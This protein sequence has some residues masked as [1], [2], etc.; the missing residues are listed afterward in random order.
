MLNVVR[1]GQVKLFLILL[2]VIGIT[3]CAHGEPERLEHTFSFQ[4]ETDAHSVAVVG[5]FNG[6]DPKHGEMHEVGENCW[7]IRLEMT[8]G[9]HHYKFVV[10]GDQVFEDP[11]ADRKLREGDGF[12]GVNSGIAI[13]K[14]ARKIELT[15]AQR[16][17]M[18]ARVRE[19]QD[20][21]VMQPD[22]KYM[23]RFVYMPSYFVGEDIQSVAVVGSLNGWSKVATP[24]REVGDGAW[25]AEVAL[26]KGVHFYK[27]VINGNRWVNDPMSDREFEL[28]DGFE[29]VNS[30]VIV[31]PDGRKLAAAR[32]NHVNE[33]AIAIE[34]FNVYE[35]GKVL[36]QLRV[37]A[38]DVEGVELNIS[39]I[40]SSDWQACL[41]EMIDRAM[42]FDLFSGV[43]ESDAR[44]VRY[45]FTIRDGNKTVYLADKVMTDDVEEAKR[46]A[47][48]EEMNYDFNVPEWAKH[49][50]WYQIFPERFRNGDP[51]NDPENTKR[52]TSEW[53]TVLPGEEG[54]F[55]SDFYTG[56]G[57]VWW[58]KYGG[59]T[60]G[61]IDALPYLRKLG[62]NA[63]YLNPV[64]EA[65]TMH[66]YDATDYRHIDDNFGVK[67]DIDR[68]EGESV[69][70]ATWQWSESDKQFLAFVDE[71][72]KQGFKVI[73][74][75]V[76]NHVGPKHY[77]FQDVLENGMDS[78][79][80]DWFEITDWGQGGEPGKPGGLQWIGWGGKNS[81]LPAW[82]KDEELGIAE[83]PS[84]HIFDITRRWMAPDGDINRGIDGWR[85]DAPNDVPHAFWKR[86]RKLVK[87]VNPD[88]YIS[89][90]IWH[91][92]QD[93]FAG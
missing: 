91:W 57:N 89:G 67:G 72:H 19:L 51:S 48:V 29:G 18:L 69:D 71:A 73:L 86:W 34:K 14:A 50:V 83:G 45:Y 36:V 52:W 30:A 55:E 15:A 1:L 82:K 88:A 68:L 24:M 90:E 77:A 16:Q 64:F 31:G 60:Q 37:Q 20:L 76:F 66:K 8:E 3:V 53:Y 25:V 42:G 59:D 21:D 26:E 10:D 2:A 41:M 54:E 61:L 27:F 17:E 85:L 65:E 23:H 44:I 87:E 93:Y 33:E 22:G 70:P 79:Y 84:E 40:G 49:V 58:R 78:F 32:E 7:E 81:G 28:P 35:Q 62:V 13:G 39:P 4:P 9:V 74:D 47:F 38:K 56:N 80:A 43:A 6:W 12:G 5:T 11:E 46:E 63:I 75:G 92:A